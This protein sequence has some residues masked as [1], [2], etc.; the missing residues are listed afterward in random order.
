MADL[1]VSLKILLFNLEPKH[2]PLYIIVI[3]T[4]L[5]Y[6]LV[7]FMSTFPFFSIKSGATLTLV[8]AM[9]DGPINMRRGNPVLL[10]F[11]TV[12]ISNL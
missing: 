5:C 7:T 12:V 8:L 3:I 1:A 4:P 11:I 9:R 10:V 6:Q 2:Q